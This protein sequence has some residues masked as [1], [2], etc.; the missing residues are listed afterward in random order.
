MCAFDLEREQ[1]SILL[2]FHFSCLPFLVKLLRLKCLFLL[3][4]SVTFKVKV[5]REYMLLLLVESYATLV[6]V[7]TKAIRL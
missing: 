4:D 3:V 7:E 1:E 5:T 2:F 6:V